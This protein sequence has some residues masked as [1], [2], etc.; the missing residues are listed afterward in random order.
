[1][2]KVIDKISGEPTEFGKRFI[3]I[4]LSNGCNATAAYQ[5]LVP[6]K[7]YSSARAQAAHYFARLSKTDYFA[8]KQEDMRDSEGFGYKARIN[9]LKDIAFRCAGLSADGTPLPDRRMDARSAI[10]AIAEINKMTGDHA[11]TRLKLVNESGT[12]G[13]TIEVIER[14]A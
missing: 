9:L 13:I 2:C 6:G 7:A 3:D 14:V 11:E 1:M 10:A 8:R 4:Y 12:G 5:T